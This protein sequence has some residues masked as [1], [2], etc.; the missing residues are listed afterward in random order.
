[1]QS[2]WDLPWLLI[3]PQR[4]HWAASAHS[5][6]PRLSKAWLLGIVSIPSDS[7][8]RWTDVNLAFKGPLWRLVTF[9]LTCLACGSARSPALGESIAQ[10]PLC[11]EACCGQRNRAETGKPAPS[12][13][14]QRPSSILPN[15]QAQVKMRAFKHRLHRVP[16][17]LSTTVPRWQGK[18]S[19]VAWGPFQAA[20]GGRVRVAC[21]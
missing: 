3:S 16:L 14:A 1:M 5:P 19:P 18:G 10:L 21:W 15:G 7:P 4:S 20:C 13:Q 2:T 11:L 12:S 17:S 6:E 9:H 8:F